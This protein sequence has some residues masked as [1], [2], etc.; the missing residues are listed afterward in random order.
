MGQKVEKA[1]VAQAE[2]V[3]MVGTEE[4]LWQEKVVTVAMGPVLQVLAAGVAILQ[5]QAATAVTGVTGV[6]EWPTTAP[7]ETVETEEMP[8]Q[9]PGEMAVTALT[10]V[11]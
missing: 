9:G 6:M 3:G 11:T 4:R 1:D 8:Q 10:A 5:L 7:A 2:T